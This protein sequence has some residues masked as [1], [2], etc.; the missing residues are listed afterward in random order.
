ML[1]VPEGT[2]AMTR[3]RILFIF[4]ALVALVVLQQFFSLLTDR[5]FYGALLAIEFFVLAICLGSL[6]GAAVL[7]TRGRSGLASL[8]LLIPAVPAVLALLGMGLLIF[9]FRNGGHH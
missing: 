5:Y 7:N 2:S 3:F 1:D 9:L 8:V 6:A 4:D